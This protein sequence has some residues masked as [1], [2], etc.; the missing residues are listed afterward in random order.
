MPYKWSTEMAD[1]M[2]SFGIPAKV[3][4]FE[5]DVHV[6]YEQFRSTILKQ[7]TKSLYKNLRLASAKGS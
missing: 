4:T 5:S 1:K 2:A 7:T 3:V 6:P